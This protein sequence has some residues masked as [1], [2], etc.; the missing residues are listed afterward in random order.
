M[1]GDT[2]Y[3]VKLRK[4]QLIDKIPDVYDYGTLLYVGGHCH[5]DRGLQMAD[6]FVK[7]NYT[8]DVIDIWKPNVKDMRQNLK[9]VYNVFYGD[10]RNFDFKAVYDVIMFWHGPEHLEKADIPVLLERLKKYAAKL[11][12]FGCPYGYYE[13]GPEYGNPYET[14]RSHW[15]R[16][17]FVKLGMESD[18]IG[19]K[20]S[21]KGN[22]L[23]WIRV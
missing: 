10:I 22:I 8:I 18:A 13:Q 16:E 2:D 5:N 11:I 1:T 9:Y 12:I 4:D 7:H 20:D 14:H 17:D 19:Y 15:D 23:S 6:E 21:L 3:I